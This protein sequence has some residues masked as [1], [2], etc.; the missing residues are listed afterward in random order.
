MRRTTLVLSALVLLLTG[1]DTKA[2]SLNA[3]Q[4]FV[5]GGQR[6]KPKVEPLVT[7]V[8]DRS[9][10]TFTEDERD[11]PTRAS[12][13]FLSVLRRAMVVRRSRRE[14]PFECNDGFANLRSDTAVQDRPEK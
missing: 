1:T 5:P 7:M 13:H 10:Q 11:G 8:T 3:A 2:L 12:G 14:C 9:P 6:F 4:Q